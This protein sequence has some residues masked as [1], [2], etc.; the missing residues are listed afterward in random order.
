[1]LQLNEIAAHRYK[2]I[3]LALEWKTL[4]DA[5]GIPEVFLIQF[6][7]D[8]TLDWEED[9]PV[10]RIGLDGD[11]DER[12]CPLPELL[13][14]EFDLKETCLRLSGVVDMIERLKGLGRNSE[15]RGFLVEHI[16]KRVRNVFGHPKD[17]FGREYDS[18]EENYSEEEDD[19][20]SMPDAEPAPNNDSINEDN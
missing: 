9:L 8:E 2:L 17:Y 12:Q 7:E 10:P 6:D 11:R 13:S 20:D 1:M 19:D 5:V 4:R 3:S 18:E 14:P 15:L 16:R